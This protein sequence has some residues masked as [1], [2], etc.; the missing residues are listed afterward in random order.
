MHFSEIPPQG[1]TVETDECPAMAAEPGVTV[2][3]C[4]AA[5]RL[6]RE[7]RPSDRRGVGPLMYPEHHVGAVERPANQSERAADQRLSRIGDRVKLPGLGVDRGRE[8]ALLD[9][10][11][12]QLW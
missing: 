7:R 4:T 3:A 2:R 10:R 5:V 9:Q 11:L 6:D 8:L 12:R 1:V